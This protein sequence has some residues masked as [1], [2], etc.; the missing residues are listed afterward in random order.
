MDNATVAMIVVALFQ[1]L[2]CAVGTMVWARI[3][4]IEDKMDKF[5]ESLGIVHARVSDANERI[6]RLEARAET[7]RR[8]SP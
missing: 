7:S 4:R 3:G 5:L 2:L 8:P 6:A 1:L